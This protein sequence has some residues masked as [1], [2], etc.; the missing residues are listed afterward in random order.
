MDFWT[1]IS[2]VSAVITVGGA[3][4]QAGKSLSKKNEKGVRA[5]FERFSPPTVAL[6][7]KLIG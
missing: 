7:K 6:Q 1:A 5:K 4:W 3:V 2:D